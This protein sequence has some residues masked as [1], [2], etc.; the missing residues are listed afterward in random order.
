MTANGWCSATAGAPRPL[1]EHRL[2]LRAVPGCPV[3]HQVPFPFLVVWPPDA[4]VGAAV[5]YGAGLSGVAAD[6]IHFVEG[7]LP[8][9]LQ[10]Q[11]V[12]KAHFHFPV[13]LSTSITRPCLELLQCLTTW[14]GC[15]G[16]F[17]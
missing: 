6:D 13:V 4:L 16:R 17:H 15:F 3:S 14:P 5:E 2:F 8:P 7:R 12:R 9:C 10:T 1:P 11:G